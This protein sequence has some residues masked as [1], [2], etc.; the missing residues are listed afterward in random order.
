MTVDNDSPKCRCGTPFT[1]AKDGSDLHFCENCDQYSV[2]RTIH[3]KMFGFEMVTE[4]DA[5]YDRNYARALREW[6]PEQFNELP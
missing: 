5:T 3:R 1:R 2:A 4:E 6:Y